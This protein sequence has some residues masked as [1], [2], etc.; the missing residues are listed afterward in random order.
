MDD[1]LRLS[2][3]DRWDEPAPLQGESAAA[4]QDVPPLLAQ[5]LHRR[6]IDDPAEA[7]AFLATEGGPLHDPML[8]AGMAEAVD[9]IRLAIAHGERIAIY[10][11][12]DA[13][14]VTATALLTEAL[15]IAGADV[16]PYIPLRS[17]GY[18]LRDDALADLARDG[19]RLVVTV[20]C[21][22]GS[23]AEIARAHALGLV[24]IVT[25]HHAITGA[26][27]GVAVAVLNPRR[28][29]GGYP[30]SGLA[31][32]GVAYKLAVASLRAVDAK[33]SDRFAE[34]ALD[35]VAIGTI[36]DVV[37]LLGENRSLVKRGL[38]VLRKTPRPG[39]RALIESSGTKKDNLD[40]RDVSHRLAPRINATGRLTEAKISLD[41]LLEQDTARAESLARQLE[42]SNSERQRLM[43]ESVIRARSL[44]ESAPDRA[45]VAIR[46]DDCLPGVAGLVASRL[47]EELTRPV[48]VL[49]PLGGQLRGSVRT[50]TDFPVASSLAECA[51]LLLSHGGH[52]RAGGFSVALERYEELVE[53]LSELAAAAASGGVRRALSIDAELTLRDL[54]LPT[55]ELTRRLAPFGHAN[56]EPIFLTRGLKITSKRAVGKNGSTH[57]RL[58]LEDTARQRAAAIAFGRGSDIDRLPPYVDIAY[59]LSRDD[60]GG[61]TRIEARVVDLRPAW[62][63][64]SSARGSG[65][66]QG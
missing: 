56:R 40:E 58:T 48:A 5:I 3:Y 45:F 20:D 11:D 66:L 10:G 33:A 37:P 16:V 34:S 41:L 19:A 38:N 57:L 26:I 61:T 36:A 65:S 44:L 62:R 54:T 30:D 9:R 7:A 28:P 13:D 4:L 21:G 8:L 12:Y 2:R 23:A 27:P 32:V 59:Q 43:E 6:G 29:D 17:E 42:I 22:V 31:G 15:Q 47:T 53:R 51:D 64:P 1:T 39:L 35:L 46:D 24:V 63:R 60:F 55:Y 18:G 49:V 50:C 14:G 52:A 25:D